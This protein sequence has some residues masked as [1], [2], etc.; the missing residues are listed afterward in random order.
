LSDISPIFL[1]IGDFSIKWYGIL[2]ALGFGI[3]RFIIK[4]IFTKEKKW[5]SK[6]DALLFYIICG[7]LIGARLGH[8]IFYEPHYFFENPEKIFRIWE[9]GLASHGTAMGI[10]V[11]I[12]LYC[13]HWSFKRKKFVKTKREGYSFLQIVDRIAIVVAL[14]ACFIRI[15]NFINAEALGKETNHKIGTHHT[16]PIKRALTNQLGSIQKV[17]CDL[18]DNENVRYVIHFS[19]RISDELIIDRY[20]KNVVI[21]MFDRL[22]RSP[23]ATFKSIRSAKTR[24]KNG[25]FSIEINMI[26]IYRHPAQLYEAFGYLFIFMLTFTYWRIHKLHTRPGSILGIFFT[27]LFGIRILIEYFKVETSTLTDA[28]LN[29]GQ[30]LSIPFFLVGLFFLFQFSNR[31]K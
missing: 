3:S 2:F 24:L 6:S 15:G 7:T 21:P 12:A 8:I 11:A 1:Q 9:G 10:L 18:V 5:H 28:A 20:L 16:L 26:P 17:Q 14:G 27:S 23:V 25:H 4:H 30:L 31:K 22:K 13:F 19:D 29:M